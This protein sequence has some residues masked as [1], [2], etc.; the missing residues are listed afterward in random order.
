MNTIHLRGQVTIVTPIAHAE[1]KPMMIT[2]TYFFAK[3]F[4]AK[5]SVTTMLILKAKN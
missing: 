5:N 1:G 3:K 4:M 2:V